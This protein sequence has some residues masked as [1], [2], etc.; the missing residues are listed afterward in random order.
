MNSEILELNDRAE[1]HLKNGEWSAALT[2]F[3]KVFLDFSRAEQPAMRAQVARALWGAVQCSRAMND[4][5]R[6]EQIQATLERR[7]GTDSHSRVRYYLELSR[8]KAPVAESNSA[9]EEM[10]ATVASAPE[11]WDDFL[12]ANGLGE[13][14]SEP[15][16]APTSAPFIAPENAAPA[17]I[18]VESE[19]SLASLKALFDAA[20]VENALEGSDLLR[21]VPDGATRVLVEVNE[22]HKL[23]HFSAL[24]GLRKFAKEDDK[25]KFANRLNDEIIF[26]RFAISDETQLVADYYLPYAG[27][28][29]PQQIIHALRLLTRITSMSIGKL[30]EDDLLS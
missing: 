20:F 22:S 21:V 8:G 5:K 16:A 15:V 26:V 6:A 30:D 13:E 2:L 9:S 14:T 12:N 1:T 25:R 27:G 10:A 29:L 24:Y 4:A 28:I 17:S 23:V 19:V 7:Y 18:I 11:N 3:Q